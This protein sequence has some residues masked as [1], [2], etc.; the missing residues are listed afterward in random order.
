MLFI[1][2]DQSEVLDRAKNGRTGANSNLRLT[3]TDLKT[4]VLSLS[5]REAM[6][7]N[8]DLFLKPAFEPFDHL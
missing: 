5:L 6:V 2:D 4:G 7:Q 8:G 3:F 1:D